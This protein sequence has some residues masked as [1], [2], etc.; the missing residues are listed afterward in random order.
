[1]S[2]CPEGKSCPFHQAVER[3]VLKRV[4]YASAFPLCRRGEFS[5]CAIRPYLLRGEPAPEDLMPTGECERYGDGAHSPG[6]SNSSRVLIVEPSAVFR[7]LARNAVQSC[8]DAERVVAAGTFEEAVRQLSGQPV[9]LLVCAERFDCGRTAHDIRAI[10]SA[11][12]IVLTSNDAAL[13]SPPARSRVVARS[14]GPEIMRSAIAAF[15][16]GAVQG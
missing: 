5:R 7:T 11:P 3:N 10:S 4:K 9:G 1:M 12:M 14:A 6:H 16:G 15:L 13:Q 8:M 2:T